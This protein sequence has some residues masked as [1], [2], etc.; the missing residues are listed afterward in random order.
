MKIG[1][2]DPKTL[3]TEDF[4][5]LP[6]GDTRLV[7][8]AKAV[9]DMEMFNTL[10]PTPKPPGKLTKAGYVPD[11]D[12]ESYK[13]VV[14]QHN[15]QRLSYLVI[16]SLQE[17]EWDTVKV[18]DPSTWANWEEDL[19]NSKITAPERHHVLGLV[20]AVNSL[21]EGKIAAARES[22]LAGTLETSAQ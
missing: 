9:D 8:R 10:C 12:D 22:F 14:V 20:M 16:N 2:I 19:K 4:L 7:I 18:D 5:V 1:G 13:F 11:T 15:Q 6:R 17:I 3:P 21:D